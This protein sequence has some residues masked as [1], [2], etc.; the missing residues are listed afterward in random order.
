[1]TTLA[2]LE[3]VER[4]LRATQFTKDIRWADTIAAY[5]KAQRE[6]DADIEMLKHHAMRA[7]LRVRAGCDELEANICPPKE[8]T[9]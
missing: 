4:E 1:M 6:R 7:V 8:P 2:D 3:R 5:V 9:P